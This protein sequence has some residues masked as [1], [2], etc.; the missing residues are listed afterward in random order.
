MLKQRPSMH[1]L[2]NEYYKSIAREIYIKASIVN[3]LIYGHILQHP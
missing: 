2:V 1:K 3:A